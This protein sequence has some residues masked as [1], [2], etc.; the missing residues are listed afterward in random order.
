VAAIVR[1]LR[2][3]AHDNGVHPTTVQSLAAP[4]ADARFAETTENQLD[5]GLASTLR[6]LRQIAGP[7]AGSE[8]SPHDQGAHYARWNH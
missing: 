6:V 1:E 3:R 8:A 5:E 7:E 2:E 4:F